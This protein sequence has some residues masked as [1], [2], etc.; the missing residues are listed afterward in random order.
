MGPQASVAR[1]RK[2][3]CFSI[4]P[5]GRFKGHGGYIEI[6][7]AFGIE[8]NEPLAI[9]KAIENCI[10]VSGPTGY[11]I[12]DLLKYQEDEADEISKK[13]LAKIYSTRLTE[14]QRHERFVSLTIRQPK[15]RKSWI[16][17]FSGWDEKLKTR[18]PAVNKLVV[19]S[20]VGLEGLGQTIL[21]QTTDGGSQIH[22]A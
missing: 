15:S 13:H 17:E 7:P 9:G 11:H 10:E 21:D 19:K 18:I 2:S 6:Y 8:S 5:F 12:R 3:G 20:E 16:L 14:R 4:R 1:N 22:Q